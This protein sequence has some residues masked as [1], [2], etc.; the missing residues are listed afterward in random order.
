MPCLLFLNLVMSNNLKIVIFKGGTIFWRRTHSSPLSYKVEE[1]VLLPLQ[2][3]H[4]ILMLWSLQPPFTVKRGL[5]QKKFKEELLSLLRRIMYLSLVGS[6]LV[7]MP[8]G[9]L[10][11]NPLKC[12]SGFLIFITNIRNHIM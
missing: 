6:T 12:G 3:S 7:L 1:N 5:Q 11:R 2:H 8:F 4:S 9:E 10:I